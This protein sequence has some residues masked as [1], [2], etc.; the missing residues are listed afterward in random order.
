MAELNGTGHTP[1][2]DGPIKEVHAFWIAGM[3]I[4]SISRQISCPPGEAVIS[5]IA[6]NSTGSVLYSAAGNTVKI[7][8]LNT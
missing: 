6:L 7:W 3:R 8:D 2:L 5:D 1:F 4:D